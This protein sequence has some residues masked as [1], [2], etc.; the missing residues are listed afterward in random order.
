[1]VA[2]VHLP[3]LLRMHTQE[4]CE[5]ADEGQTALN[6]MQSLLEELQGSADSAADKPAALGII[7]DLLRLASLTLNRH[8]HASTNHGCM[9]QCHRGVSNHTCHSSYCAVLFFLLG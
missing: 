4:W 8:Q 1:M 3:P 7:S 6:S 5:A 9:P 2:E